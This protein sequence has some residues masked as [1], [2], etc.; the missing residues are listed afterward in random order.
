MV[1]FLALTDVRGGCCASISEFLVLTMGNFCFGIVTQ[2]KSADLYSNDLWLQMVK[3]VV[4]KHWLKKRLLVVAL[5]WIP[6]GS[7]V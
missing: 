1:C 2:V 7:Q 4:H 6:Q 5:L 3:A